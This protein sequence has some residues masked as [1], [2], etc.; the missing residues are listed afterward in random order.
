MYAIAFD[1]DTD[2]LKRAYHNES[3]NNAYN[4]IRAF[5]E[6]LGFTWKQGSVLFGDPNKINAV[7]CVLAVMELTQKFPW[8]K[9]VV[10]DIR[11]LR[12]EDNNDLFP[13]V[14]RVGDKS[15]TKALA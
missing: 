3:Y 1:L 5:L 8:F 9:D 12:I 14:N 4:D 13:I 2:A 10:K 11:M 6:P 7:T 15:P